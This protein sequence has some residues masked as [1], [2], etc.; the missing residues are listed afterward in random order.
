M[1]KTALI[2]KVSAIA[3]AAFLAVGVAGCNSNNNAPASDGGNDTATTTETAATGG[4]E[5]VSVNGYDFVVDTSKDPKDIEIAL[6]YANVTTPFAQYLKAGVDAYAAETGINAYMTAPDTWSTENEIEMIEN[7]V[8][9]GVDGLAVMVLDQDAMTPVINAALAA[10]IPTICWN[11]DDVYSDRLGFIGEDLYL[12][13]QNTARALVERMGEEGKV[14]IT[15]EDASTY[16]SQQREQGA[17][18]YLAD[19]PN[20]KVMDILDCQGADEQ[21]M[22]STIE[23]AMRANDDITGVISTG[24]TCY[25]LSQF[26]AENDIGNNFGDDPI[27]NTGHDLREEKVQDILDGWS[28]AQF[29]QYPYEQGYEAA[30]ML[31]DFLTTANSSVFK[32]VDTGLLEVTIDNAQDIMDRILAGEIIG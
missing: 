13:G 6:V 7:L 1:K 24:G 8:A 25:I 12:A 26:L 19:Y 15:S 4:T 30:K 31:G 11:V 32:V 28:T 17:R 21:G 14:L 22:Y 5:T 16:H 23:A 9:K 20:I 2:Q 10:G 27:W 29:G 18:D 3:M